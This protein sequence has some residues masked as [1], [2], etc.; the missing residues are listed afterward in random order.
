M[1][2]SLVLI[3]SHI[4]TLTVLYIKK[5]KDKPLEIVRFVTD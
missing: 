1:N 5:E 3:L 4:D 2:I